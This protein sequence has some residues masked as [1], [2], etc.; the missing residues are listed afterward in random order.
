MPAAT[1]DYLV[2]A[3][4]DGARTLLLVPAG[5]AEHA[6]GQLV[7]SQGRGAKEWYRSPDTPHGVTVVWSNVAVLEIVSTVLVTDYRS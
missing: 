4:I 1:G 3:V 5:D 6:V 2:T 7:M